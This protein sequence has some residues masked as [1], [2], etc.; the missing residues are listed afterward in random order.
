[1]RST[2]LYLML[3]STILGPIQGSRLGKLEEVV[4]SL[5]SLVYSELSSI[6]HEVKEIS[7][8]VY[9]LENS[10]VTHDPSSPSKEM[11][12]TSYNLGDETGESGKQLVRDGNNEASVV[13][14]EVQNIRKA[15]ANDKQD[16]HQLKQEFKGQLRELE[17]TITSH[18][19][20]L[21]ADVQQN[22]EYIHENIS[23]ANVA[24]SEFINV[25]ISKDNI[26]MEI[27]SFCKL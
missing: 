9:I 22:I 27:K 7:N 2:L 10:T 17:Q 25:S 16:L 12:I 19:Y 26:K 8:R 24:L 11:E 4:K 23:L 1:M 15:Y 3:C 21:T 6:R 13:K 20:N 14:A 5:R 18:M